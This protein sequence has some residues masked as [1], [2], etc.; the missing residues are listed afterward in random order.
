MIRIRQRFEA[1]VVEDVARKVREELGALNL[2]Q[3]L[4]VGMSHIY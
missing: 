1:P 2:R 4:K 3:R